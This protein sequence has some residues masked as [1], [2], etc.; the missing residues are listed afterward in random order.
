MLLALQPINVVF[1]LMRQMLVMG[2]W[3]VQPP[4]I[5]GWPSFV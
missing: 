4:I 5:L 3:E 2:V 1:R